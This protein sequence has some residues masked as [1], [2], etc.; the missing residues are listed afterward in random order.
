MQFLEIFGGHKIQFGQAL[1]PQCPPVVPVPNMTLFDF[2]DHVTL[3]VCDLK[4]L[5]LVVYIYWSLV[6]KGR[7]IVAGRWKVLMFSAEID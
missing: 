3:C 2:T 6:S 7:L 4:N 5:N 1:P